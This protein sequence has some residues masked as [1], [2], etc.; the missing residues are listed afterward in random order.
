VRL[1]LRWAVL[2]LSFWITTFIV[3][4]I[5]IKNGAWN[6]FWVAALFGIINT[7]LGSILKL[8]T[9][10]AVILSFGLFIFVINAAMLMLTDRW[11]DTVT[12]D[13]FGSA[14]LGSLIIS[15]LSGFINKIV[16]RA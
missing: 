11:S 1:L 15:L 16:K 8:L 12:I 9:L 2:A 6:Y 13:S 5:Q 7:V 4:G 3:S 14:L 10:P